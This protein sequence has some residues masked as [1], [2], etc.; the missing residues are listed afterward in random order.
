MKLRGNSF[1]RFWDFCIEKPTWFSR[2]YK[3]YLCA[4]RRMLASIILLSIMTNLAI[5][6]MHRTAVLKYE[7]TIRFLDRHMTWWSHNFLIDPEESLT[8]FFFFCIFFRLHLFSLHLFLFTS[9]LF[10]AS[11]LFLCLFADFWTDFRMD[12][13]S[14]LTL[15]LPLMTVLFH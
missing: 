11:F 6:T 13:R 12:F 1:L 5:L 2:L 4:E 3:L 9:F 7:L 15:V 10:V 14:L 8:S